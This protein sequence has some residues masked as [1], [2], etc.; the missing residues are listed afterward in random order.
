MKTKITLGKPVK[1]ISVRKYLWG[2]VYRAV[3]RSVWSSVYR[4]ARVPISN[5]MRWDIEL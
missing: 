2:S 4:S 3:D 5:S 1:S